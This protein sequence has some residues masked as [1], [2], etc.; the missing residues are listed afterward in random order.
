MLAE[1]LIFETVGPYL[2]FTGTAAALSAKGFRRQLT[3][4][5]S[6]AAVGDLVAARWFGRRKMRLHSPL[7]RPL[8]GGF[9]SKTG[10]LKKIWI[11][12]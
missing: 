6:K 9:L 3:N 4:S 12:K 5:I 11:K 7:A 1:I 8:A 10:L 2:A